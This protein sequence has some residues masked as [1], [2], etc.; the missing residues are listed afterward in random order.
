MKETLFVC[1]CTNRCSF[2]NGEYVKAGLSELEQ[3]CYKATEEV[4][5]RA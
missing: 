3:W 1:V 5:I 4:D 2:G